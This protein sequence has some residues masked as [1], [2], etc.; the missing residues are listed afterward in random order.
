MTWVPVLGLL[1]FSKPFIIEMD[2]S[3]FG[4]GAVLLQIQRPIACFSQML[5]PRACAKPIYEKKLRVIMMAVQKWRPYL[6]DDKF[7]VQVGQ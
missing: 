3:E 2:A 5:G 6:L 4:L 7:L 1:D